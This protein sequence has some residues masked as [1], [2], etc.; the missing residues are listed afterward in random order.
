MYLRNYKGEI[1]FFNENK[2]SSE[3]EMYIELWKI[4]YNIDLCAPKENVMSTLIHYI[5]ESSRK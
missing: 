4:K 3:Y 1:V 5:T 2:Y